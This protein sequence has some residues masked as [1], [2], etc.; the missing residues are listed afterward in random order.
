M[1]SLFMLSLYTRVQSSIHSTG[2]T[3]S[4][5]QYWHYIRGHSENTENAAKKWQYIIVNSDSSA[6][7]S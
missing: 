4:T 3:H 7:H 2:N 1:L 5:V 6:Q